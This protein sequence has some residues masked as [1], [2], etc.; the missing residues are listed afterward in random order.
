LAI[1]Q[2]WSDADLLAI[3]KQVNDYFQQ[4]PSEPDWQAGEQLS[5]AYNQ[6]AQQTQ[7]QAQIL[8]QRQQELERLGV[9][10]SWHHPFGSPAQI[11]DG[12]SDRCELA[13]SE[14]ARL[15]RQLNQAKQ[16]FLDWQRLAQRYHD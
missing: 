3:Q 12:A 13:R 16:T 11:F 4:P 2:S 5:A 8:L 14:L 1:A 10:R 15:K 6:L 9:R 7:S